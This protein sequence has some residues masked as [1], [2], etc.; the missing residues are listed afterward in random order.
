[1]QKV[2]KPEEVERRMENAVTDSKELRITIAAIF[3]NLSLCLLKTS[4]PQE[5]LI[6]TENALKQLVK[7]RIADGNNNL[8]NDEKSDTDIENYPAS[9]FEDKIA[10]DLAAKVW[11]RRGLAFG[12]LEQTQKKEQATANAKI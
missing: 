1:M 8:E 4:D 6:A 11:S 12:E 3:S 5:A 7:S 10:R 2:F 9:V